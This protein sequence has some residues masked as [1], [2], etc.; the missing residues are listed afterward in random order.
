MRSF[1]WLD[2]LVPAA[3]QLIDRASD[4]TSQGN[5]AIMPNSRM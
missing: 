2:E 4:D 3:Q 1:Q 5:G